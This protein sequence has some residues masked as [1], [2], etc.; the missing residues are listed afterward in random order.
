MQCM[1]QVEAA[2]LLPFTIANVVLANSSPHT[3]VFLLMVASESSPD[4]TALVL[5]ANHADIEGDQP[6]PFSAEVQ[7]TNDTHVSN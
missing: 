4:S 1:M 2:L 6:K 5:A 7:Y 3:F